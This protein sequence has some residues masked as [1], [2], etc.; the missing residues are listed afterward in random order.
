MDSTLIIVVVVTLIL[1]TL[2]IIYGIWVNSKAR[3]NGASWLQIFTGKKIG[4][5]CASD[6]MCSSNKC[7]NKICLI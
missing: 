2:I 1:T 4:E 3:A 7:V 6:G 5:F